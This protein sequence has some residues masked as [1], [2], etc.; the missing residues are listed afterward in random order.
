[1]CSVKITLKFI[2]VSIVILSRL[3]IIWVW[4]TIRTKLSSPFLVLKN[5]LHIILQNMMVTLIKFVLLSLYCKKGCNQN[6]V[7]KALIESVRTCSVL[8]SHR[9]VSFSQVPLKFFLSSIIFHW[10]FNFWNLCW[11]AAHNDTRDLLISSVGV[12][13]LFPLHS[14]KWYQVWW[15]A[16]KNPLLAA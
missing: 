2:I 3:P 12:F 8:Q 13:A 6:T 4:R 1:M 11:F 16:G 14:C 10:A 5:E 7:N 15:N 9:I